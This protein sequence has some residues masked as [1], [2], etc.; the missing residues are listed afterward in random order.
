V[1]A[2]TSGGEQKRWSDFGAWWKTAATGSGLHGRRC[3]GS[4]K[5]RVRHEIERGSQGDQV[6]QLT[7]DGDGGERPETDEGRSSRGRRLGLH[8]RAVVQRKRG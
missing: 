4:L 1:G 2:L 5:A 7:G 3:S 8:A 6:E